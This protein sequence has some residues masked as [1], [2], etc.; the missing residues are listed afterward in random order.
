M[1]SFGNTDALT[2]K[3]KWDVERQV[4]PY[5]TLTT[6]TTVAS[7]NTLTF[8]TTQDVANANISVGM[9]VL[10]ANI[11]YSGAPEFFVSNT[12]VLSV[13][14]N[15]VTLSRTVLG[16]VP[17]GTAV[18]FDSNIPWAANTQAATYNSDT[19][20]VTPTRLANSSFANTATPHA[21][22]VHVQTGTGGRA[23]RVQVEVLVALAN[24]V[25]SNTTS[26]NT[27]NSGSYYAGL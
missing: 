12:T 6:T 7:G 21:G 5:A 24:A 17:T 8:G 13:T 10:S 15:T 14:S 19:V 18:R 22:W 1:S 11:G 9:S 4:R 3:P 20:L 2:D 26:G 23:G 16:S 25:A 27:S